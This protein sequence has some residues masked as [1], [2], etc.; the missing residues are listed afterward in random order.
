MLKPVLVIN[1]LA[2]VAPQMAQLEGAGD[3]DIRDIVTDAAKIIVSG[4]RRGLK[5]K[6]IS[7]QVDMTV[8]PDTKII[9]DMFAQNPRS[10]KAAI[11]SLRNAAELAYNESIRPEEGLFGVEPRRE[12]RDIMEQMRRGYEPTRT[13]DVAEAERPRPAPSDVERKAEPSAATVPPADQGFQLTGQT[14]EELAELQRKELSGEAEAERDR[15]E[16]EEAAKA[17]EIAAKKVADQKRETFQLAPPPSAPTVQAAGPVGDLFGTTGIREQPTRAPRR[18]AAEPS[19][20]E[21]M[22]E[23]ARAAEEMGSPQQ[24]L[25]DLIKELG[26]GV[27]KR[28]IETPDETTILTEETWDGDTTIKRFEFD[29]IVSLA[30]K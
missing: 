22:A 1:A 16:A 24:V 18:V 12:R 21:Q 11:E 13:E 17:A 9:V 14:P 8:D 27:G 2:Q 30:S 25:D 20:I 6:E 7:A 15:L 4:K 5:L 29:A 26:R 19:P 3:L 28:R 23:D 10:N